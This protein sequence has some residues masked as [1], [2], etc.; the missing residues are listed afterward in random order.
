MLTSDLVRVRRHLGSISVL[1]LR[2][3][4]RSRLILSAEQFVALAA[5]CVGRTRGEFR[6][7]CDDV[8]HEET[9]HKLVK[10]L[11]KLVED[12]CAFQM[13]DDLDPQ[14]VRKAVF[15]LASEVRGSSE[16]PFDRNAIVRDVAE[17]MET[18]VDAIEERLYADLKENH[19]L[20]HFEPIAAIALVDAYEM[21]QKQ[22]ALLRAVKVVVRVRCADPN[23]YRA[24]FRQMKFRRLLYRATQQSDGYYRIEID[25]PFSLFREV[26]K[27]GLQ[28]ALL[29]PTLQACGVWEL[30]ADV[31]WDNDRESYRFHLEGG[32][33]AGSPN[34]GAEVRLPD[35]V[36]QLRSRFA[37]LD[38][39]WRVEV[40]GD[41]LDLP[42]VGLCVPDLAFTH[43]Q[44][45]SRVY[46]EALGYWSREA[47]WRRVELV[48]AGLP[49]R[50]I[51][52]V[53]DRLRVS[54]KALDDE[55]PGQLYVYKGAMSASAIADRLE[56]IARV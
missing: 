50:I 41:L 10:G 31:R 49:H 45:G 40:A 42:G 55:L 39:P 7:A 56:A 30:D 32:T 13:T 1:P 35:E 48:Q 34:A 52:A 33:E 37:R 6:D 27:Y 47:V 46:L 4:E 20:T 53:S 38:T 25:G 54:E 22:A 29:L 18:T 24:L 23:G 44:S 15:Q 5:A 21:A 36:E 19:R 11:R 43:S 16:G 28:L 3:A 51:F 26:T 14:S 9:D 17:M 12:R 8:P 2:P